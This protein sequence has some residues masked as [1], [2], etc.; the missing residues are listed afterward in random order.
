[1]LALVGKSAEA[2]QTISS[3][4]DGWRSIGATVFAPF[5]SSHLALAYADL[6]K[7]DDA[8]RNLGETMTAIETSKEKWCEA[9]INRVAGEI[10]LRSPAR[11]AA[12][13]QGYFERALALRG[14]NRLNPGNCARQ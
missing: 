11:D 2:I 6:G 5:W 8:W 13:A 7:F 1:M 14:Y 12:K 3:G 4:I 10:A 9:E